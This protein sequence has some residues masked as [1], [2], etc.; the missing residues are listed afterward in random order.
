VIDQ[1]VRSAM[2]VTDG[3]WEAGSVRVPLIERLPADAPELADFDA[4]VHNVE[5]RRSAMQYADNTEKAYT[6][7]YRR[8]VEWCQSVGYQ[9]GP[10]FITEEKMFEYTKYMATEQRYALKTIYQALRA[11]KIYKERATGSTPSAEAALGVLDTY[12][13]TLAK[14]DLAKPRRR[15]RRTT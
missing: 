3:N 6:R 4:T 7:R 14:L 10:E 9:A 1:P 13:D 15:T 12:R 8:Y 5:H 11:L 2:V